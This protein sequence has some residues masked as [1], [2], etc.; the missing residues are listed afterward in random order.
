MHTSILNLTISELTQLIHIMEADF[1]KKH[2]LHKITSGFE[3]EFYITPTK[4]TLFTQITQEIQQIENIFEFKKELGI[5]TTHSQFEIT[6]IPQDNIIKSCQILENIR[7][8]ITN[9]FKKYNTFISFNATISEQLPPSSLQ[10][11]CCFWKKNSHKPIPYTN[12]TFQNIT[13]NTVHSIIQTTA[14]TSQ[15]ENCINRICNL[16]F[17]KQFKN[18]PTNQTWGIENRT[19]AIRIAKLPNSEEINRL[20]LRTPSSYTNAHNIALAFLASTETSTYYPQTFIDSYTSES[21]FLPKTL[22][23]A[24]DLFQTSEIN[25]KIKKYLT[26]IWHTKES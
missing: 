26:Q 11:N 7:T 2:S 9:I 18:S 5:N 17:T 20:E 14:L 1:L 8:Q 10:L 16:N 4:K 24:I 25:K 6:T 21:K 3:L 12:Q 22:N 13:Q 19:V 15:T 23:E